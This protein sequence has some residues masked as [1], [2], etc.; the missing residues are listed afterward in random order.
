MGILV[1]CLVNLILAQAALECNSADDCFKAG[2]T[3]FKERNFK[4]AESLYSKCISLDSKYESCYHKR[5]QTRLFQQ[6]FESA[7]SDLSSLVKVNPNNK[8]GYIQL[9]QLQMKLGRYDEV[10]NT[11]NDI[12]KRFSSSSESQTAKTLQQQ[13]HENINLLKQIDSLISQKQ[14]DNVM[15]IFEKLVEI[16]PYSITLVEKRLSI[17]KLLNKWYDVIADTGLLLKN[18]PNDLSLLSERGY[19]YIQ[20]GDDTMAKKHFRSCLQS[21]PEY[22]PCKTTMKL[23][24]KIIKKRNNIEEDIEKEQWTEAEEDTMSLYSLK[25]IP[26]FYIH[27]S[28]KYL[29]RISNKLSK[30]EETEKYCKLAIEEYPQEVDFYCILADSYLLAEKYQDAKNIIK[31]GLDKNERNEKLSQK[32]QEIDTA[33]KRSKEKDYY[34]ILGVKRDATKKQI[35][36]AYRKLALQWHPDKHQGDDKEIAEKKFREIAEAYEILSDDENRGK[37]DRGEDVSGQAQN[38]QQ[39][40]FQNFQFNFGG[41]GGGFPGGFPFGG[42]QF[43]GQQQGGHGGQGGG[44][45][46][47]FNFGQGGNQHFEFH[48]G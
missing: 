23:L 46:G 12:I 7:L 36:S 38:A 28:E 26:S 22:K 8:K 9:A 3:L 41:Q 42:F 31:Q 30:S 14:Y 39:N 40:P 25:D 48:M 27:E 18:N 43:G 21:D 34:K 35:K 45:P 11:T 37:Y 16:S 32:M 4:Q 13:A 24:N 47:G 33:E 1:L 19:A 5:Y 29:C 6:R 15:S 2:E 17:N 10:I 44:F 20:L